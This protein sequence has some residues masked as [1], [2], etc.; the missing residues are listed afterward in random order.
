MSRTESDFSDFEK[1]YDTYADML[2]RISLAYT[3]NAANA[4]DIVHDVFIKFIESRCRFGSEEHRKAW[5]IRVT[6]N[7]CRDFIRSSRYR[8]YMPLD[9]A[10]YKLQTDTFSGTDT[11][12]AIEKLP[13]KYKA[14]VILHY[15]EGYT[16]NEIS[17]ML[18]I[19]ASAVKMRLSRG[20]GI[21]KDI[22]EEESL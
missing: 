2:Y 17:G 14:V 10:E 12:L 13:Y 6:V 9:K 1:I 19:S 18:R 8:N 7:K 15:L 20:R 11:A 21:L 16:V 4:E 22:A 5:F 3:R